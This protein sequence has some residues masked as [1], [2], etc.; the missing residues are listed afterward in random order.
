MRV[1]IT[2]STGFLGMPL[3]SRLLT[4]GH[5]CCLIVRD[6]A[7]ARSMFGPAPFVIQCDG[8]N[9]DIHE[10]VKDFSPE[11]VIHLAS[12]LTAADD[13]AALDLLL[14]S[15]VI[16]LAHVLDAL[17]ESGLRLFVNTGSFSEYFLG[18]DMLNPAYLYSATKI[19]ARPIIEYYSK[20][21]GFSHVNVIPYTVYGAPSRSRKVL[22]I[23]MGSLDS[24]MVVQM[25]PGT[26]RLDF[27]HIDDVVD[28]YA[29]IVNATGIEK[30][31]GQDLH[32]GTGQGTT[33]REV[34]SIFERISGRRANIHWGGLPYR[35]RDI[36]YSVAPGSSLAKGLNWHAKVTLDEGIRRLLASN[37]YE[38]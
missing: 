23:I 38:R 9:S 19:A 24:P 8:V 1:L 25:T 34:V 13:R 35:D 37:D 20:A 18:D 3:T 2:G 16:F 36:M 15:N 7:R 12:H 33:L 22:D 6:A 5:E 4:E 29:A 32:L 30:F 11:T 31:D 21:R 26:Q 14:E 17:K 10:G 28:C 27:I